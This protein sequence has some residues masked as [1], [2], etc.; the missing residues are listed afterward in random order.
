MAEGS[1]VSSFGSH[2]DWSRGFSCCGSSVSCLRGGLGRGA[3][4]NELSPRSEDS[5]FR[6]W[7]CMFLGLGLGLT[8]D[9]KRESILEPDLVLNP[10]RSLYRC[11]N[12]GTT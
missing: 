6:Q 8:L 5:F 1:V 3:T 2:L 12:G 11:R 7:S 4:C 9:P 10:F